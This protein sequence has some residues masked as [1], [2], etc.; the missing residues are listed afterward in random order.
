M[1]LQAK[2]KGQAMD[3]ATMALLI[4]DVPDMN[5]HYPA[6]TGCYR[7]PESGVRTVRHI[8]NNYTV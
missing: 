3:M 6:R 2:E 4:R 5:F 1:K 7:I 8:D